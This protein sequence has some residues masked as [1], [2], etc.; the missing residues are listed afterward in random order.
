LALTP[1]SSLRETAHEVGVLNE[2][3]CK[4]LQLINHRPEGNIQEIAEGISAEGSYLAPKGQV[5]WQRSCHLHV[6]QPSVA[7]R[8]QVIPFGTA[9]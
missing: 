3:R 8:F 4:P 1:F 7:L 6:E 5:S 2:K 9:F